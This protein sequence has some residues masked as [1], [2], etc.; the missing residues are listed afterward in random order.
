MADWILL[1]TFRS[2]ELEFNCDGASQVSESLGSLQWFIMDR[3]RLWQFNGHWR[4][5]I[6]QLGLGYVDL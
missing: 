5:L 4:R 6:E 3:N 1:S 2:A